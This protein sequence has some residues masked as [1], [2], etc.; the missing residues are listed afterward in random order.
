MLDLFYLILDALSFE[1][2]NISKPILLTSPSTLDLSYSSI[3]LSC[4]LILQYLSLSLSL[5][6][7]YSYLKKFTYFVSHCLTGLDSTKQV[8]LLFIQHK[9]SSWIKTNKK[10]ISS[11]TMIIGTSEKLLTSIIKQ[12]W[13]Q[14]SIGVH[15]QNIQNFLIA[16]REPI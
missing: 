14:E 4:S 12:N 3:S 8:N 1:V 13:R 9:Q 7:T 10:E 2:N 15:V 11:C 5:T 6:F 16:D